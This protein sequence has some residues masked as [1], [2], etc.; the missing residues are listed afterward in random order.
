MPTA[1]QTFLPPGTTVR[2]DDGPMMTIVSLTINGN[3]NLFI[4]YNCEWWDGDQLYAGSFEDWR[5]AIV[6]KVLPI[7]F[8]WV[9][10]KPKGVK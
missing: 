10:E 3:D 4:E 7:G 6:G 8:K 5:L 9:D 1:K 2:A